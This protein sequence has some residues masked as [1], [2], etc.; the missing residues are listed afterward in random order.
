MKRYSCGFLILI[1]ILGITGCNGDARKK[2][3]KKKIVARID[4]E[5]IYEK[6][7]REYYADKDIENYPPNVK[8]KLLNNMLTDILISREVK[9]IEVD[10]EEVDEVLKKS[11]GDSIPDKVRS[12]LEN[13][14][15]LKKYLQKGNEIEIEIGEDEIKE[16]YDENSSKFYTK[17]SILASQLFFKKKEKA[18]EIYKK[19]RWNKEK[20]KEFTSKYN[21][22]PYKSNQGNL[23]WVEYGELPTEIENAVFEIKSGRISRPV[24]SEFGFH[25]FW[26]RKKAGSKYIPLEE[27]K[28]RIKKILLEKKINKKYSG[29]I[30]NLMQKYKIYINEDYIY[31]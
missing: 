3:V 23:G 31:K 22:E 28:P 5:K 29:L 14:Y 18:E 12:T 6:D 4:D 16:Y 21:E 8:R 15:K 9:N 24:K 19:V 7:F 20:F 2:A 27:A 11:Y 13:I 30:K 17:K 26:V 25:I 10:R 1:I